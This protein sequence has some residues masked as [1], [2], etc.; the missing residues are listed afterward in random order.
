MPVGA[1]RQHLIAAPAACR[2]RC[3]DALRSGLGHPRSAFLRRAFARD[4]REGE[5][6]HQ[7]RKDG[8]ACNHRRSPYRMRG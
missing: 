8:I 3:V 6:D 7:D 5:A 4:H 2:G 1:A